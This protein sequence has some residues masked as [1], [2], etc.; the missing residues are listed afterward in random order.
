MNVAA[1]EEAHPETVLVFLQNISRRNADGAVARIIVVINQVLYYITPT[2]GAPVRQICP[3]P[4]LDGPVKSLYHARLLLVFTGKVLDTVAF[5]QSLEVR[6]EE[7]LALV[8]L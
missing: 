3:Y 4:G 6:V 8:C 2:H 7:L 1:P 5:L